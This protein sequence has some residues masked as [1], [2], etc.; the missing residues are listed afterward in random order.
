MKAINVTNS[1]ICFITFQ[2]FSNWKSFFFFECT[3]GNIWKLNRIIKPRPL[4]ENDTML[5]HKG[6]YRLEHNLTTGKI[7]NFFSY[8]NGSIS[9]L[10][11]P[12][13]TQDILFHQWGLPLFTQPHSTKNNMLFL[14]GKWADTHF[15]FL[16]LLHSHFSSI[17]GQERYYYMYLQVKKLSILEAPCFAS[18]R[19]DEQWANNCV[20][21]HTASIRD[22]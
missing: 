8:D 2:C 1:W 18:H 9:H 13:T 3:V 10:V 14:R 19:S 11:S 5:H 21:T 6:N 16:I 4:T 12:R 15:I 17:S 20:Q 22:H 7:K